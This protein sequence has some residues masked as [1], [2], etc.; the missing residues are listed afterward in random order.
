MFVLNILLKRYMDFYD[1]LFY[2]WSFLKKYIFVWLLVISKN[3]DCLRCWIKF[4]RN[5][6]IGR[7]LNV[8]I[9]RL[10]RENRYKLFFKMVF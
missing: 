10:E 1:F 2:D 5:D 7:Y 6:V 8:Y 4:V 9:I 3:I